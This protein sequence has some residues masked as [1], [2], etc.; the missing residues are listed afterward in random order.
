[1]LTQGAITPGLELDFINEEDEVT[2]ALV[3][4]VSFGIS[5]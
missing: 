5:F 2:K 1:M 3:Y 4:G